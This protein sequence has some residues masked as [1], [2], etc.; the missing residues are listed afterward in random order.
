[1]DDNKLISIISIITSVGFTALYILSK[2]FRKI[3]DSDCVLNAGGNE[4]II[5]HHEGKDE[6]RSL[7][8]KV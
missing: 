1:M 5:R 8:E 7:D 3:K 2:I 4:I 6:K